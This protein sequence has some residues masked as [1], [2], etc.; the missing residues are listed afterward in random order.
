MLFNNEIVII[1][2][3]KPMRF[4]IITIFPD[5]FR[6][7]FASSILARAKKKKLIDIRIHNLRKWA[8][9][10]HKTVDDRPYGGGPGMVLKIEPIYR[11]VYAITTNAKRQTTK[12][13][14]KPCI[15]LFSAKGKIL[16]Q[17][18]VKK[19]AK[20]KWLILIC[21]HY[22]G[23]DERVAKYIA[24]EEISIGEYVLTGGEIPAMVLVDAVSRLI[25]GVVGK[26]ASLR[27]ESFS[28]PGWRE[29][30]QY[31]RPEVFRPTINDKR[32]TKKGW[33]VPKVLL[34]GDHKKIQ[35]WRKKHVGA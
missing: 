14:G 3:I 12:K 10:R 31:T 11:A 34:S 33:R 32:R 35:E 1:Y 2:K 4:D 5:A 17:E 22:E 21:G 15:I 9:D 6:S 18:K 7:Y 28:K 23:V 20:K 8:Y 19:L 25:P 16:T 13:L 29:Y 26:K 27:E 24:D 30:P